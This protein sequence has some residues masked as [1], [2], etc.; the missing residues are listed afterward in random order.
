MWIVKISTYV[1]TPVHIMYRCTYVCMFEILTNLSCNTLS[2]IEQIRIIM[3]KYEQLHFSIV[4]INDIILLTISAHW[5]AITCIF[6]S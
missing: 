1:C 2:N 3:F 4:K 6:K 5:L